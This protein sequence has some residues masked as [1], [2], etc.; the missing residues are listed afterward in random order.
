MVL[1]FLHTEKSDLINIKGNKCQSL[2]QSEKKVKNAY[3]TNV[4]TPIKFK[5]PS[6][7][8]KEN[9]T[10]QRTIAK[11]LNI[12]VRTVNKIIKSDL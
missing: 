2:L 11:S 10:S 6:H 3:P 7:V 12:S 5:V 4:C 1:I 8:L 9:L